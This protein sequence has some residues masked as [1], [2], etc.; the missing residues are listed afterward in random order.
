MD[1]FSTVGAN[2]QA[3]TYLEQLQRVLSRL[4]SDVGTDMSQFLGCGL[5]VYQSTE[6]LVTITETQSAVAEKTNTLAEQIVDRVGSVCAHAIQTREDCNEARSAAEKGL[7]QVA[8][9][10]DDVQNLKKQ[11]TLRER[12]LQALG[13][14][15]REVETILQTIGT[16][17]SRTDLLQSR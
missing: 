2:G 9:M 12:K 5:E 4:Q 16:L 8:M 14:R 6:E 10:A 3:L 15:A 1:G 7:A 13:Q 11:S 17:S